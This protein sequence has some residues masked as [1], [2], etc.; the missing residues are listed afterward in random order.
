VTFRGWIRP[1]RVTNRHRSATGRPHKRPRLVARSRPFLSVRE[2]LEFSPEL[3]DQAWQRFRVKDGEKGPM[4]WEVKHVWFYPNGEDDLPMEPMHLIVARNVLEPDVLKFFIAEAPQDTRLTVLLHVAFSR[5]R[6]ERSFED[7]KTELGFDHFEGRSYIGLMRHQT[8]TALTHLFLSRVHQEWRGE[9]P[10]VD[11]LPN[12]HGCLG[13]G[14]ILVVDAHG[15]EQA[16]RAS[17]PHHL[18]HTES[19]SPLA[20]ESPQTHPEEIAK[21]RGHH[22]RSA[23]M[24]MEK[25]LAL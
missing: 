17:R 20:K 2:H 23:K 7:Q 12:S 18:R 5:W 19:Q 24:R 25:Y 10:G 9:K 15:S 6:V 3:R 13:P 1:P 22:Q 14:S 4:V 21:H 11:S 8:I 16:D